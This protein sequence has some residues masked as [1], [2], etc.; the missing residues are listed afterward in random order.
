[1]K[2]LQDSI[3]RMES[4]RYFRSPRSQAISIL[5]SLFDWRWEWESLYSNSASEVPVVA[6][7]CVVTDVNG[8]PQ[9]PTMIQYS[10]HW[11]TM[12]IIYYNATLIL[13]LRMGKQHNWALLSKCSD[14]EPPL[15]FIRP[16]L[17][18]PL[19]RPSDISSLE[20]VCS[21]F[22]RSMEC[23]MF[24]ADKHPGTRY[25][26]MC[27][28]S[29]VAFGLD[30]SSK[31]VTWIKNIEKRMIESSTYDFWSAAHRSNTPFRRSEAL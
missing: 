2:R 9:W 21:E 3:G 13:I 16:L 15:G 30:E 11:R 25:Q 6:S 27:T 4:S 10:D 26:L 18:S 28:I 17:T 20:D 8:K 14:R 22:Y 31:E 5:Q 19:L 12:E 29:L 24:V 7:N 1:M 23:Y